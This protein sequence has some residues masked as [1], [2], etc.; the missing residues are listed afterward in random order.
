VPGKWKEQ[1]GHVLI[2]AMA[3]EMPVIG[4]S[5]GAIPEVIGRSDLIF[6]EGDSKALAQLIE[7]LISDEV[8]YEEIAHYGLDRVTSHYTHEAIALRLKACLDMV[9]Q[10]SDKRMAANGT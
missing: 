9:H 2:E 4:S 7:R 8:F 3:M 10:N 5:S 6:P 1:F